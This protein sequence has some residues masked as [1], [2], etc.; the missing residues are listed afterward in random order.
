MTKSIILFLIP[1]LLLAPVCATAIEKEQRLQQEQAHTEHQLM[2]E[3]A[4]RARAEAE[5][6][7][8]E[9]SKTAEMARETTARLRAER[10]REKAVSKRAMTEERAREKALEQEELARAREELGRAHRELREATREVA[11]AHRELSHV[12]RVHT[13]VRHV[14]LGDRAVIGVVLGKETEKGVEI[15]GISPDGPAERAGLQQG[16]ILVSIRGVNLAGND[17]AREAIFEVMREAGDG[18]ELAVVVERDGETWD[19]VVTAEMREPRGWQS[20]IRIPEVEVIEEVNGSPRIIVERIEVPDVDDAELAARVAEI[21]ARVS[22]NVSSRVDGEDFEIEFEEFSD[23]G[24]HVMREA[25]IWFGLPHAHGLEL[26]TVNESLGAYFKTDHGVLV[27]SAKEDNAYGLQSGDVILAIGSTA[28]N[29]PSDMMRA[30]RDA[31]PGMEI[32]LAIKRDRRDRT[33]TAVMPENRLG[34]K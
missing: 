17:E 21:S 8:I 20:V 34:L 9:A 31:E 13:T 16:D 18:E 2:L 24:G 29:S 1:A 12:D 14:N 27:I 30:L 33:L 3:E 10:A 25:N 15:M 19:Y 11:R 5:T 32:V 26:A 23:L 7:R 4:E 22:A 28:V 6:M